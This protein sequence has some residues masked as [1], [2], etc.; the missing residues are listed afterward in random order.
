MSSHSAILHTEAMRVA[1]S[2]HMCRW[3]RVDLGVPYG[4]LVEPEGKYSPPNELQ[5]EDKCN[6]YR[7]VFLLFPVL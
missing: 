2:S 7:L 5:M 1:Y 6:A 3:C 4:F